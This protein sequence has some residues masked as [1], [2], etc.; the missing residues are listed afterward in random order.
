MVPGKRGPWREGNP[1]CLLQDSVALPVTVA[2]EGEGG[3]ASRSGLLCCLR[4]S[5]ELWVL[6]MSCWSGSHNGLHPRAHGPAVLTPFR[7]AAF[8]SRACGRHAKEWKRG[9]FLV[10]RT[11]ESEMWKTSGR[12]PSSILPLNRVE[13]SLFSSFDITDSRSVFPIRALSTQ[14][15]A[16]AFH[17]PPTVDYPHFHCFSVSES[18]RSP[19]WLAHS[20]WDMLSPRNDQ[21]CPLFSSFRKSG[22]EMHLAFSLESGKGYNEFGRLREQPKVCRYR[23]FYVLISVWSHIMGKAQKGTVTSVKVFYVY[24]TTAPRLGKKNFVFQSF[25]G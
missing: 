2:N 14:A 4:G 8:H 16:Y 18:A 17:P 19:Q 13:F 21:M 9:V 22:W 10:R 25:D 15:P 3:A 11:P 12:I 24:Y 6:K 20:H 23:V 7:P 5:P 1:N